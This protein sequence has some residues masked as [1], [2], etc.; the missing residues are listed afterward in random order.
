MSRKLRVEEEKARQIKE[1]DEEIVEDVFVTRQR[2][3]AAPL[4]WK[5]TSTGFSIVD[6]KEKYFH[7]IVEIFKVI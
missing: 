4:V 5:R 7:E 6:A 1:V 2:K 3:I